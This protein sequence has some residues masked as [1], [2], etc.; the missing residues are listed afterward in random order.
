VLAERRSRAAI[1]GI[2]G[3]PWSEPPPP[4]PSGLIDD[5]PR[6]VH[7]L[8]FE[9][10]STVIVP[11]FGLIG[12]MPEAAPGQ[13]ADVLLTLEDPQRLL[14]KTHLA[15]GSE[16]GAVWVAD[17]GSSNGTVVVAPSGAETPL[18]GG[19]HVTIE[20]GT[21]VRVGGRMFQVRQGSPTA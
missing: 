8:V 10:G 20:P 9:D 19:V 6:T 4:P 18:A 13:S 1:V 16:A 7:H 12:R 2:S 5:V 15:F 3:G 21:V 11:G 14:S 17:Q